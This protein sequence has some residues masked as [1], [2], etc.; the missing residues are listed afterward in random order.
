[1][2]LQ[3]NTIRSLRTQIAMVF[4]AFSAALAIALCFLAGETLKLRLQK[5]AANSLLLVAHNTANMLQADLRQQSIRVHV[6]A[7]SQELWENG[8]GSRAVGQLLN[9]IQ[10]INPHSVWIGV[11]DPDG[12]VL[13]AT[14]NMLKGSNVSERPWFQQALRGSFI[15][16]VHPAKLLADLLPP[17]S[18]GEPLR[19]VDFSTPIHHPDGK[20][21][22]VI[23]VHSSWDWVHA[24]VQKLIQ[25]A[26]KDSQQNIFIFDAKGDLIYAPEGAVQPYI[27]LGQRI[28]DVI[29]ASTPTPTTAVWLDR[30]APYLTAA[31]RLP[32]PN[33]ENDLGWWIVARQPVETAYAD[34]NRVLWLGLAIGLVAGILAALIAWQLAGHLSDDLKRLAQSASRLNTS[35]EAIPILHSNREVFRL[36]HTLRHM[37]QQLLNANEDMQEQVRLRTLELEVANTELERQASTDLLTQLQNRRGFENRAQLALALARRS[38]RPLSVMS[39]DVDFFKRINDQYGHDIG[40]RVLTKF[41]AVLCQRTR[42]TDIVARFGGEEF[43]ILLPDTDAL[44]AMAMAHDLL[45]TVERTEMPS[46]GHITASAGVSSLRNQTAADGLPEMIKRSDEALYEAKHSGRNRVSYRA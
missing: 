31:V 27:E 6:L 45:R 5:Q 28:P 4:G 2:S 21:L 46:V 20:L 41:A 30:K 29:N 18:S 1:M 44:A 9:R 3:K 22:G 14:G 32:P 7:Q 15:S 38:G 39:L 13:N 17:S 12:K 8:L 19:L 34:A 16:E 36:S 42:Q 37:T 35:S 11:S 33:E 26:D 40:D 24:A 43:V 25:G 23:G 10:S